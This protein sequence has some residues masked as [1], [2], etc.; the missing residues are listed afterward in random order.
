MSQTQEKKTKL[1]FLVSMLTK[2]STDPA[3][4]TEYIRA[5]MEKMNLSAE[6]IL[7][8]QC[9]RNGYEELECNGQ[10]VRCY[11]FAERGVGL[12]RNNALLRADGDI[13]VFA[14]EDIEY[15]KNAAEKICAEF[16]KH[17]EAD[18]LLFNVKVTKERRTYWN[19]SFHRVRWYNCG[20][21]PAYSFAIRTGKMHEK[22]LTYSLL[23]GGGARFSNGEDS[24]FISD[25]LKAGLQVYAVPVCIGEEIPRPSTWFFGYNE[26]FF[27]DRGVLYHYLYG[28]MAQIWGFRFLLKMKSALEIQNMGANAIPLTWKQACSCLFQGIADARKGL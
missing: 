16:E 1:Q 15:E 5:H 26:K 22:N 12:S 23:F 2:E 28:R 19:D 21:Y 8:H 11:H 25:C 14:D 7:I 17:P 20:R 18:M 6:S 3:H 9:D 27:Y 10:K 13:A 4:L 24:L